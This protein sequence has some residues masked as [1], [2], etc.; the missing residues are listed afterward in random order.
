MG[1]AVAT[2]KKVTESLVDPKKSDKTAVSRKQS[3]TVIATQTLVEN[4]ATMNSMDTKLTCV[5]T[6]LNTIDSSIGFVQSTLDN[7]MKEMEQKM[8]INPFSLCRMGLLGKRMS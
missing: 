2:F 7:H 8:E 5:D 6:R 3:V 1:V 4:N